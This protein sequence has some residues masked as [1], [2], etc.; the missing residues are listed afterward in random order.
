MRK[1]GVLLGFL[2]ATL[3]Y[4]A[5]SAGTP[6]VEVSATLR[7]HSEQSIQTALNETI[8]VGVRTAVGTGF[9]WIRIIPPLVSD[10]SV[11][12]EILLADADL[13]AEDGRVQGN[14]RAS[15]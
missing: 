7:N 10:D 4:T 5:A 6:S 14:S 12:I 13:S 9:S 11:T 1:A 8:E 2:G 3:L 15:G